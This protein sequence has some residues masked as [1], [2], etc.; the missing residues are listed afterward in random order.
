MTRER[1]V[2]ILYLMAH[3][4]FR[5]CAASAFAA[6]LSTACFAQE[7]A[8][9]GALGYKDSFQINYTNAFLPSLPLVYASNPGFHEPGFVP[10]GFPPSADMCV[11]V[12]TYR[13]DATFINCCSCRVPANTL[14]IFT[15]NSLFPGVASSVAS[16]GAVVK[17]V[18]TLSKGAPTPC[19]PT[20]N[21]IQVGLGTPGGYSSGLRAWGNHSLNLTEAKFEPAP[22]GPGEQLKLINACVAN[23]SNRCNCP[24][25]GS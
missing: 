18:T 22:L 16:T 14:L 11:N 4:R 23:P 19:D 15:G 9:G 2:P 20:S 1:N 8:T 12:Y 13:P 6:V 5:L 21:P 3:L 7:P 10:V 25:S 24:G 17:L